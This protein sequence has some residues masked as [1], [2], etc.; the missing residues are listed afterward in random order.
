MNK[1]PDYHSRYDRRFAE[2]GRELDSDGRLDDGRG[3][4]RAAF[5]REG[6]DGSERFPLRERERLPASS[7]ER[8]GVRP[9]TRRDF[10]GDDRFSGREYTG[11]TD[12]GSF[13][14]G[15]DFRPGSDRDFGNDD[16]RPGFRDSMA[17]RLRD[18][19]PLRATSY[20]NPRGEG[21]GRDE[22]RLDP[23]TRYD[24]RGV[25]DEPDSGGRVPSYAE[26]YGH[27]NR[28]TFRARPPFGDRDHDRFDPRF[29]PERGS[30]G[31]YVGRG[32]KGYVRSDERI[33]EELCEMLY[34]QGYV[35]TA[36]IEVFV[37]DGEVTFEGTVRERDDKH[38]LEHLADRVAGVTEVHNKLRR[39]RQHRANAGS[40]SGTDTNAGNAGGESAAASSPPSHAPREN[41]KASRQEVAQKSAE[42][43]GPTKTQPSTSG[44][45]QPS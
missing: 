33:R 7:P 5:G 32:P 44:R 17:E 41:G 13:A 1:H 4:P 25:G 29:V 42:A 28:A 3:I 20:H 24:R 16:A 15:G 37:K 18:R 35:D 26:T 6:S 36:D 12:D 30:L 11:G 21:F 34:L 31:P 22:D 45:H 27:T 19:L 23:A 43:N 8:F 14:M 2:D 38:F 10:S 39:Q 9:A 40:T